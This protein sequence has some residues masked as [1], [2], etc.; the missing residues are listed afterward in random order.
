MRRKFFLLGR[1]LLVVLALLVANRLEQRVISTLIPGLGVSVP[2]TDPSQALLAANSLEAASDDGDAESLLTALQESVRVLARRPD[3]MLRFGP[4]RVSARSVVH[5]LREVAG[6][7][8][9]GLTGPDLMRALL[10]RYRLYRSAAGTGRVLFTGYYEASLKGSLVRGGR[11]KTP[12]YRLPDDLVKVDLGRF[13]A[14]LQ[15]EKIVGRLEEGRLVPYPDRAAIVSGALEGKGLELV[16][17][18]DPVEAFFLQIQGSGRVALPEGRSMRVHYA[19]SNGWPYRSIGRLLIEEGKISRKKMSLQA[20]RAY[21]REHP[22]ERDRIFNTNPSYVFFES[23]KDGPI[24][25]SGAVVTAGRSIATDSRLFPVAALA[26]LRAKR[27]VVDE[28]GERIGTETMERIVFNQDTGGAIRGAGRVDLFCG[29]GPA[30]EA[31]AGQLKDRGTL[32]F[33][34]PSPAE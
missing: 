2:I 5:Q 22:E 9:S 18:D 28:K 20:L 14:D 17:V 10:G 31:L 30:A 16:W 21:L 4:E 11:Y 12:L 8:E 25:S 7:V 1:F 23:R 32:Y 19:G 13:R 15:E 26:F 29:V 24:G 27:P 6:L 34:S 3:S 33:F